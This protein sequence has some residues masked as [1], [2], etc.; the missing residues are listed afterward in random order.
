MDALGR[1]IDVV[2][3]VVNVD[4]NTAG[5]TGKR[6]SLRNAGGVTVV[7]T[8]GAAA[9]G[10]ES[11]VLTVKQHTA[12]SSGTTANLVA[13]DKYW[14]KAAATLAGSETWTKISQTASQTVTVADTQGAL[15]GVAQKQVEVVFEIDGTQ[16]SDGYTHFSVDVADPGSVG[17]VVSVHYILRDLKVQRAP[18]NL[19]NPQT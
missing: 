16:L 2:P 8:L 5:A 12:A 1:L 17:R 14:V 4:A 9:S 11:L 10:T 19:I 7:A 15:T 3:G 13:V 6:V 18:E